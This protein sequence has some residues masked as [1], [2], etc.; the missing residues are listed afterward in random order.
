MQYMARQPILDANEQTQG[1]EMLYRAAAQSF[2]QITDIDAASRNVLEQIIILGY[3]EL[4]GGKRLYV[5]CSSE[6]LAR[7]YIS[8]LPPD[9]VVVEILET[10]EPTPAIIAA[11]QQLKNSGFTIALDDF[12]PNERTL[13]LL[14]FADIIKVD[15]RSTD[16]KTRN[17]IVRQY[18][19]VAKPLAEKV[20]TRAEYK[21]ALKAGYALFQ[22]Y[23][24]CEPVLLANQ[25]L[26]PSR[27]NYMRLMEQTGRA[28][29]DFKQ[30]EDVI[31]CDAALCYRLL[32]YLN[33]YAFCLRTTIT[34]IRHALALL[35]ETQL[36]RWIAVACV[37]VAAENSSQCLLAT[38]LMRARFAELL[39]LKAGLRAYECFLLG[40]F[41][42]MDSILGI[43]IKQLL[44]RVKVPKEAEAALL[45]KQNK[46]RDLLDLI[47][48]HDR[49]NFEK[50]RGLCAQF[51]IDPNELQEDYLR[52]LQWVDLITGISQELSKPE[53]EIPPPVTV[54]AGNGLRPM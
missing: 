33:S 7:E 45:G 21:S 40:M 31:K 18:C 42:I 23:F 8:V 15:F 10:V 32:R 52:A 11:C 51:H 5:N 27:V 37:S 49:G 46:M 3:K 39:A 43:P 47:I 6:V 17:E 12:V 1:Y 14:P 25:E 53:I 30:V 26:S 41:S 38:A 36:R 48:A 50:S 28:E 13:P 35:G 9:A 24:F 44:D 4:S 29:V 22:G 19:K 54:S 34:S 2:A 16:E 20:E